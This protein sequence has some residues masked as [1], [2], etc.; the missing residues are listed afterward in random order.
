M[1]EALEKKTIV[2]Q[3]SKFTLTRA[4]IEKMTIQELLEIDEMFW[5]QQN[6]KLHRCYKQGQAY[7]NNSNKKTSVDLLKDMFILL[8]NQYKDDTNSK[9]I[10]NIF[11]IL[12]NCL[13]M[14]NDIETDVDK[15]C[16]LS[17]I[18]GY[19]LGCLK[20]YE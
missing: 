8:K 2:K 13:Q 12:N 18:Q 11:N 10:E 7:A 3:P 5:E 4:E 20:K 15:N 17:I 14:I 19:T 1:S 16:I 6:V 9:Q